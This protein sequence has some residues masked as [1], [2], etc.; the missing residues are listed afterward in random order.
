MH[1]R[2]WW[3]DG[4]KAE[5]I[6]APPTQ[7]KLIPIVT[8]ASTCDDAAELA[9]TYR[10]RWAAQENIIRDFLLPLGLDTNHGYSKTEVGNSEVSKKRVALEKRLSNIQRWALSA[11]TR[12]RSFQ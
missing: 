9:T 8:T 6:P 2:G 1:K 4:W 3:R 12:A 7:A 5:P 11:E 10:Q